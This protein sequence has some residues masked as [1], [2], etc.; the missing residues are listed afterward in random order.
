MYSSVN[1]AQQSIEA[2]FLEA[3]YLKNTKTLKNL[4]KIFNKIQSINFNYIFYFILN[5][6]ITSLGACVYLFYSH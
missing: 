6:N 1:L 2:F 5:K 3:P 4:I